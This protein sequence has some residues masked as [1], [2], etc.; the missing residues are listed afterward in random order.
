MA[1][2]HSVGCNDMVVEEP[3]PVDPS[4]PLI[5]ARL[6]AILD[7]VPTVA[8]CLELQEQDNI[9]NP[10][11]EVG[12]D[13]GEAASLQSGAIAQR[14]DQSGSSLIEL[15]TIAAESSVE[16]ISISDV[17]VV[18]MVES[19]R[20]PLMLGDRVISYSQDVE[21]LG[22]DWED[23]LYQARQM[24]DDVAF[25][26]FSDS[27]VPNSSQQE[28]FVALIYNLDPQNTQEARQ[29]DMGIRK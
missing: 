20:Q 13:I 25:T 26:Q 2:I 17:S 1:L 22:E 3:T 9:S 27:D 18:L 16:P 21:H 14:I 5:Y 11:M 28:H 10:D 6:A 15:T 23:K 24:E 12:C 19:E 4:I 29:C 8:P 7:P